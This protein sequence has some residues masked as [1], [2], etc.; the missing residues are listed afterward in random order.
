MNYSIGQFAKKLNRTV[1]TLQ[2]W[3][4]DGKLKAFRMP[5]GRRYY[6]EEQF[7]RFLGLE[8][9]EENKKV[10]AYSRVSSNNQKQDLQNQIKAL[11]LFCLNKGINVDSWYSEIGSALNYERKKFNQILEEVEKGLIKTIII[12]HKDR[13]V[14][15]GFKWFESFIKKHNCELIVVN[16]ESFSPQEEVVNDLMTIIHCFSSRLYGLR[17]YKGKIKEIITNDSSP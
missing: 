12:A 14:R 5:N 8:L 3:D 4:R 16:Q 13:L 17:N 15:F 1:N 9:L 2:R 6:T 7:R 11:E 10:I